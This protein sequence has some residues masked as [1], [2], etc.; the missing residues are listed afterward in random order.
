MG[1]SEMTI[2]RQFLNEVSDPLCQCWTPMAVGPPHRSVRP[3]L[4]AE[5][6]MIVR[7]DPPTPS[8]IATTK[9]DPLRDTS[10]R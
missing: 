10:R 2:Y 9:R 5:Y 7:P 1:P 6:V 3:L 4:Y 8:R